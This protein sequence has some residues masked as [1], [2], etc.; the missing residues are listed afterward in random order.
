MLSLINWAVV[1][2]LIALL[3][4][5]IYRVVRAAVHS[6]KKTITVT[7]A[8]V[9]VGTLYCRHLEK[10]RHLTF[11]PEAFKVE[12]VLYAKEESWGFGPGG[13]ETGIIVYDLPDVTAKQITK[14]GLNYLATIYD[15]GRYPKI[16]NRYKDWSETP[17]VFNEEWISPEPSAEERNG[18]GFTSKIKVY[19]LH[20]GYPIDV[21]SDIE[22]L[23]DKSISEKGS[24][25]AYGRYGLI[26]VIPKAHR[27]VFAYHG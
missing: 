3:S 11:I 8:L 24:Y 23:V 9:F 5:L 18:F 10:T 1:I 22:D 17:I 4:W 16:S 19:L 27:V 2:L 21:D 26:I 14:D 13:A 6:P 25:Y 20:Y 7:M 12:K 15:K